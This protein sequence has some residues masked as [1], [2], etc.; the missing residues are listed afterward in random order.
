M[1]LLN[2]VNAQIKPAAGTWEVLFSASAPTILSTIRCCVVGEGVSD[3]F[4]IRKVLGGTGSAIDD[5]QYLAYK[6][7]IVAGLPNAQT[8]GEVL[9]QDESIFVMSLRG[10][11]AF[12]LSGQENA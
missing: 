11:V 3:H 12:N 1:A 8:E 2:P 7:P 9:K 5:A 6:H 4:Y 10:T